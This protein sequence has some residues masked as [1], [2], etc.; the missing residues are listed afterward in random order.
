MRK[1]LYISVL[2]FAAFGYLAGAQGFDPTVEVSRTY[3]STLKHTPKPIPDMAVPDS[4]LR[5]DLDFDYSVFDRPFKGT[6]DYKPYLLDLR[7][8]PN[9]Y[10]G[11]KLY[12]KAGLGYT[13]HPE[14]DFVYSPDAGKKSTVNIYASHRSYFGK[15]RYKTDD[16]KNVVFD[17]TDAGI[18][19]QPELFIKDAEWTGYNSFTKVGVNGTTGLS[20]GELFYNANYKGIHTKDGSVSTLLG[21]DKTA[22]S[23]NAIEAL[24]GI[25]GASNGLTYNLGVSFSIGGDS[26]TNGPEKNLSYTAYGID[27]G[28][29]KQLDDSRVAL[30][31]H[32]QNSSYSSKEKANL[33]NWYIAPRYIFETD[34]FRL[35]LGV[36]IGSIMHSDVMWYGLP[37]DPNKSQ[38]I[39]PDAYLAYLINPG[40]LE[41]YASATGGDNLTNYQQIKER[42]AFA[43]P[44][45]TDNSVEHINLRAGLRGNIGQAFRYDVSAGYRNVSGAVMYQFT[46]ANQR[47]TCFLKLSEP[48]LKANFVYDRKPLL[49]EGNLLVKGSS[50]TM[51][52]RADDIKML[53]MYNDLIA[54]P[55]KVTADV[56]A[57]YY[58]KSRIVGGITL[59]AASR[60]DVKG[61]V[62]YRY[63]VDNATSTGTPHTTK[64][65]G[66]FEGY[67][68]LG[69]YGEYAVDRMVSVYGRLSN[70][71]NQKYYGNTLV[72]VSGL[73][74]TFGLIIN[75]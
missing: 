34:G 11:K 29:G 30:D 51:P 25:R 58:W 53:N 21:N 55:R 66:Y 70:L 17:N 27:G 1:K 42:D 33:G 72:P 71:L 59:K 31:F 43:T 6:G 8:Q 22:T 18:Y 56:K 60:A 48:Y 47:K 23:F 73:Y 26:Y 28:I 13:L 19:S 14:L 69:L 45:M 65:T 24:A 52:D 37:F 32:F 64:C 44:G 41:F 49:L 35:N 5:F 50:V 7:P 67:L 68:D 75:L 15:N 40:E 12:L 20:F 2:V 63:T 61:D 54:M 38:I 16:I 36:K 4:L 10:R 9:A 57:L 3:E 62:L 39:Y 46:I 74:A